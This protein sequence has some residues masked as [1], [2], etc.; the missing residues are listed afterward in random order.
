MAVMTDAIRVSDDF[1]E[2]IVLSKD[3]TFMKTKKDLLE[4]ALLVLRKEL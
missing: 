4:R 3:G 2:I 1:V